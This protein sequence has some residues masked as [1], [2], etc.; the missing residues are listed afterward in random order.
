MKTIK[1]SADS[2]Q[3]ISLDNS[4]SKDS[5]SVSCFLKDDKH[6][7]SKQ[8]KKLLTINTKLCNSSALK[9]KDLDTPCF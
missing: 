3:S 4:F 6:E 5:P 2:F 9:I 1:K 8:S 7:L